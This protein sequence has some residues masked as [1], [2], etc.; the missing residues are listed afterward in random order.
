M[1]FFFFFF[2][3]LSLWWVNFFSFQNYHF[4]TGFLGWVDFFFFAALAA[5]FFFFTPQV[6]EVS[7]FF[8]SFNSR[9]SFV[10]FCFQNTSMPPWISNGAPLNLYSVIVILCPWSTLYLSSAHAGLMKCLLLY[11][12]DVIVSLLILWLSKPNTQ[13]GI[14]FA[15]SY[16]CVEY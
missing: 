11:L 9:W 1:K 5:K 2:F 14:L 8:F 4:T 6:S 12:K 16:T 15:V 13:I 10:L 3:F 7:F